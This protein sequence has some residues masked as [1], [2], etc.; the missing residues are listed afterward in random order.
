[1]TTLHP[2]I[3]RGPTSFYSCASGGIA[4]EGLKN[5][6]IACTIID[7]MSGVEGVHPSRQ[8]LISSPRRSNSNPTAKDKGKKKKKKPSKSKHKKS[9]PAD[10]SAP[11]RD[12]QGYGPSTLA[13][14]PAPPPPPPPAATQSNFI[15]EQQPGPEPHP[16]HRPNLAFKTGF[17]YI[18]SHGKISH[19]TA[20]DYTSLTSLLL[21]TNH[22]PTT[23]RSLATLDLLLSNPRILHFLKY[24]PPID[25]DMYRCRD[26]LKL[27]VSAVMGE[28]VTAA[29][30]AQSETVLARWEGLI[31]QVLEKMGARSGGYGSTDAFTQALEEAI[32]VAKEARAM[33]VGSAKA[34]GT[35]GRASIA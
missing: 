22:T 19:I 21:D 7:I 6:H 5:N 20:R 23:L 11:D 9:Q 33:V 2:I 29:S 17:S 32:A 35:F 14:P 30:M 27:I 15:R 16:S 31:A 3:H 1:M 13:P 18:S 8:K 4:S 24:H 10:P 25:R 34:A 28:G 26:L 12:T